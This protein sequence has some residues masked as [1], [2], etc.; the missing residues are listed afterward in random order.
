[1]IFVRCLNTHSA[2]RIAEIIIK[3]TGAPSIAKHTGIAA[4]ESIEASET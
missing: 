4:S 3:F 1:M 2:A